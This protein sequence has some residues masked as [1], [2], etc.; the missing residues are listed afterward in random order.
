MNAYS[1]PTS[2]EVSG[3]AYPIRSD[4]RAV[5]DILIAMS[6]P[7]AEDWEKQEIM[8]RILY[9]GWKE[10]PA[11]DFAE[12]CRKAV[13]FIDY[14]TADAKKPSPR[15]LD[16]EQDAALII[17]A[18]NKVAGKEVRAMEYLHWWTFLGYFMEIGDGLF[19][20]V[21]GIRQKKARGK[22]LEKWEKEFERSNADMIRLRPLRSA[23]EQRV[24][25]GIEKWL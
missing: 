18:V 19:S 21:L 10:I 12:A 4:F 8:F 20:Q 11:G 16:W 7:D 13:E 1:L 14:R 9:P 17:P 23:E 22:K 2:L 5:L 15:V 25:D 3:R 6:D 24:L